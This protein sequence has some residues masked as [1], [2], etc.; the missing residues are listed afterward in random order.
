MR[1]ALLF[2]IFDYCAIDELILTMSRL[3]ASSLAEIFHFFFNSVSLPF[4]VISIGGYLNH[5]LIS[6]MLLVVIF[7]SIMRNNKQNDSM[8]LICNDFVYKF[9]SISTFIDQSTVNYTSM[10]LNQVTTVLS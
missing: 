3:R 6:M 10:H 8:F 7:N 4:T 5:Y 9:S 1:A 2:I